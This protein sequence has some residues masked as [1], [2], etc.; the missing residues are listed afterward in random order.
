M[1]IESQALN[2]IAQTVT[3]EP[4][5]YVQTQQA[6]WMLA[7][8]LFGGAGSHPMGIWRVPPHVREGWAYAACHDI[9]TTYGEA[10]RA[11]LEDAANIAIRIATTKD[12]VLLPDVLVSE[13]LGLMVNACARMARVSQEVFDTIIDETRPLRS[14]W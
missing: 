8:H 11:N 3:Q 9:A 10:L 14:R 13:T 2:R 7:D 12:F 6:A 5:D 1:D 4:N